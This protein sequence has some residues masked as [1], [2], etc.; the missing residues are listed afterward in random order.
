MKIFGSGILLS[1]MLA[2]AGAQGANAAD[3]AA[4][5]PGAAPVIPQWEVRVGGLF[6]DTMNRESGVDINAEVLSRWGAF[7]FTVPFVNTPAMLRPHLGANLNLSGDTSMVYAGYSLTV[8]VTDRLFIEGSFGGMAHNGNTQVG[9]P[10]K[11]ALGCN[12]MFRESAALG[13]RVTDRMNVSAIIEHSSN[14]GYCNANNG[15][16]NVGVRLGYTY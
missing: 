4:D 7:A 9:N 10:D 15:L 12:V 1:A 2:F 14:N 5:I 6:H 3:Y 16:T 11:L 8:D 13:V